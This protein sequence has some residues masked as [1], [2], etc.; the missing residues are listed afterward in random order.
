MPPNA[1]WCPSVGVGKG[2]PGVRMRTSAVRQ[3][4]GDGVEC[5]EI[6]EPAAKGHAN[7]FADV[8]RVCA[9][10]ETLGGP[11]RLW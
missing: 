9:S 7:Q 4:V 3:Q 1:A 10:K 5:E 2:N 6:W 11:N 8:S